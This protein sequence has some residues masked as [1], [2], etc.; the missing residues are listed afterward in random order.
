MAPM[1]LPDE[2]S[3]E[4]GIAIADEIAEGRRDAGRRRILVRAVEPL[5]HQGAAFTYRLQASTPSSIQ[6]DTPLQLHVPGRARPATATLLHQDD[7]GLTIQTDEPIPPGVRSARLSSDPAFIL[8]ALRRF[9]RSDACIPGPVAQALIEGRLLPAGVPDP[10]LASR[11]AA[12]STLN[13]SQRK[14]VS[15]LLASPLT[16]LWGPPGTGKTHTLGRA[17]H[18]WIEAGRSVLLLAPTNVAVDAL[19]LAAARHRPHEAAPSILRVG[20]ASRPEA[21]P[22]TAAGHVLRSNPDA[23]GA[24]EQA[25]RLVRDGPVAPGTGAPP[26]EQA[27]QTPR[28]AQTLLKAF[29]ET[30]RNFEADRAAAFP[31]VAATLSRLALSRAL[32]SRRYDVVIVDEASMVSIP[33]A[34]AA[35]CCAERHVVFGGDPRQLPPICQS[36]WPETR[37]WLGRNIYVLL[38]IEARASRGETGPEV[39]F[40]DTQYRMV[41]GLGEIVSRGSYG[42]RLRHGRPEFAAAAPGRRPIV[43]NTEGAWEKNGFCVEA[44]S[45]Y[46][47]A[48]I[49]ILHALL[50]EG[51]GK[52]ILLLAPFRPQRELLDGLGKDLHAIR[53]DIRFHAST[54]HRAQGSESSS[55]VVD[56]TGHDPMPTRFFTDPDAARLLNVAISRARDRLVLVG[57]SRMLGHIVSADP[58]WQTL[59]ELFASE[60]DRRP[61]EA[62]FRRL[63]RHA[64][65][66]PLCVRPA[67][68]E[69][70]LYSHGSGPGSAM[71]GVRLLRRARAP[72]KIA[73]G[74]EP[75]EDPGDVIYR[76]DTKRLVPRFFLC[77]GY[78]FVPWGAGWVEVRSPEAARVLARLATGHL[79][80][81][82]R[83]EE[84]AAFACPDCCEGTLSVIRTGSGWMLRC[85]GGAAGCPAERRLSK[86]DAARKA[87]LAGLACARC[88]SPATARA[89]PRGSLFLGCENY[90]R[91]DWTGTLE[92]LQGF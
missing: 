58:L 32:Q 81:D 17:V 16:L 67:P 83:R 29:Q 45:W 35:A 82:A 51:L 77:G 55:V 49:P 18:E 14:A 37:R 70:T 42:G 71:E 75:V 8:E 85:T 59:R 66:T 48:I 84:Q 9:L 92:L 89:G 86:S 57:N 43:V 4:I 21:E 30:C 56:L 69:P 65:L 38:D 76:Q 36:E 68:G 60:G 91:C 63:S 20:S 46:H 5:S 12:D 15:T 10:A 40:L 1:P 2:L 90:P 19:V 64:S 31:V 6:P 88:G 73:I 72:R 74:R 80:E 26:P 28:D 47:Y 3:R 33:Y 53:P 52:D 24:V 22:F 44:K 23:A 13:E 50:G 27:L 54:I 39:P 41:P 78:V 61:L 34:L 62:L 79:V 87:R 25:R 7:D 11:L